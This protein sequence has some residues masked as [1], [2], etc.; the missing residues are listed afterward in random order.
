M[1]VLAYI[2]I[3]SLAVAISIPGAVF[4]TLAG[5]LLFGIALGTVYVVISATLG[6]TCLFIAIK[7]ALE[8]WLV[9]S[10]NRWVKSMRS[11][12]Q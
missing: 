11:G 5:G 9:K 3:Y 6:A 8:P 10:T 4:L 7:I 12:F 2:A 1:A